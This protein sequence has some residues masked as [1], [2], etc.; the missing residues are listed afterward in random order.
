MRLPGKMWR[1]YF[2]I[3]GDQTYAGQMV[4]KIRKIGNGC[5][6]IFDA[7]LREWA[8]LRIG[9]KLQ[10]EIDVDGIITLTPVR[11]QPSR[12]AIS[13]IIQSTMKDYGHTMKRLA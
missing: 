8:Q 7:A 12:R 13:K 9:D 6:L 11:R 4:K 3:F 10:V 5:G 2:T 1:A